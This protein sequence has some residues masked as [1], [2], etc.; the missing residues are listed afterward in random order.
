MDKCAPL[1]VY[2]SG[3]G[4]LTVVREIRRQLSNEQIIYLADSARLPYGDRTPQE[5]QFFARQI[6]TFLVS[7]GVKMVVIACNTSSAL[8]LPIVRKEFSLPL[9]GM[10]EPGVKAALRMSEEGKVGVIAT[11]GTIDSDAYG[12]MLREHGVQVYS[13]ACPRFV[14]LIENGY[15]NSTQMAQA[16]DEYLGPLRAAGVD[17]LIYGCTHYPFLDGQV[18]AYM[19]EIKTVDPAVEAVREAG[20]CLAEMDLLSPGK[21]GQDLFFTTGEPEEFAQRGARLLGEELGP[22]EHIDLSVEGCRA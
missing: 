2:D 8:A 11:Q 3:V 9:I 10:I 22:V 13:Q 7:R 5:I 20:R 17:T 19:G 16:I 15:L 4:G 21:K 18:R 1:G 12:R 14:P 6:I